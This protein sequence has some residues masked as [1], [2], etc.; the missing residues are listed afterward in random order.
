MAKRLIEIDPV[1][2]IKTY[3]DYD[4]ATN[5]T[6]IIEE[7]DVE[8]ILSSNKR[9]EADSSFKQKGIKSEWLKIASIPNSVITKWKVEDGVDVFNPSHRKAVMRKLNDP[10]YKFLRTASGNY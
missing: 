3:H 2:G 7:Q 9:L 6:F 4:H 5:T 1:S 10:E 8:S